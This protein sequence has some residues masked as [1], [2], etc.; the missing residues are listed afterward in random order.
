MIEDFKKVI[1][2]SLKE[3]QDNISKQVEALKEKT[4]KFIKDIQENTT[5]QE[6]EMNK[7]INELK[8][9][10]ETL[11]KAQREATLE[12]EQLGK[13]SGV[14]DTSITNRIQEIQRQHKME[15][16]P[17]SKHT[18]NPGHKKKI[19]PKDNRYRG[20]RRLPT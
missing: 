4:Q 7:T 5:K 20:E 10:I 16:A 9:E 2:N 6:K 12:I 18:G 11:K 17:S 19:K 8:M 14:I 13:R 3:I 1:N 15:K